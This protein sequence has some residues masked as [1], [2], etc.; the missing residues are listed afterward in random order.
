MARQK[1]ID[2]AW[3][4]YAEQII[5]ANAPDVQRQECRRAFYAGAVS[6]FGGIMAMLDPGTEPTDADLQ[7]MSALQE[8]L[9]Q[10]ARDLESGRA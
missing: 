6:T 2:A 4:S 7:K 5:P 9:D 1:I 8:E 10:Y 3:R